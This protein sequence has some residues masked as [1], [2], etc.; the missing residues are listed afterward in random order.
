MSE[1]S[2]LVDGCAR[3]YRAR[4]YCPTHLRRVDLYG[5]PGPVE[6]LVRSREITRPA[7]VLKF[8]GWTVTDSGCWEWQGSLDAYGYG[9]ISIGGRASKAHRLS[10]K[11]WVGHI[12]EGHVVRHKCDNPPCVNPDHLETGTQTDNMRDSVLRGRH[13]RGDDVAK[14]LTSSDVAVIRARY[15]PRVVSQQKLADEYGVSRE[16]IRDIV[17]NRKW[18]SIGPG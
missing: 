11:T 3:T 2:C 9:S 1:R 12:P 13:R 6:T 10:Y 5:E 14:K 16:M 17:L 7:D 8:Y 4:G 15:Q 18:V